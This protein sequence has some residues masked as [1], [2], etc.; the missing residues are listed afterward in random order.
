LIDIDTMP[1]AHR[2]LTE[3]YRKKYFRGTWRPTASIIF[4]RGCPFRCE[5]CA[6]WKI[7]NGMYRVRDPRAVVNEIAGMKEHYIHFIDDNTLENY[8]C[9]R[10]L[11]DCIKAEGIKK[12]YEVYGR[13]DTIVKHPDLIERWR[14]IG[15]KLVLIGFESISEEKLRQWNK[16]ISLKTNDEAIDIL[17]SN[18]IEIAAY[19]I[20]DPDFSREDFEAL[21]SYVESKKL[22]HPIFTV[23]SPFPGTELRDKRRKELITSSY[24]ILDF[25]HTVLP[26]RLP[27]K[28]FY[29]H[30]S[31]LY[32]RAYASRKAL[33]HVFKP[34]A[35]FS[36]RLIFGNKKLKRKL[37]ELY[38]H[39]EKA[40]SQNGKHQ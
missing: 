7:N 26:T 17:H 30:F 39:H 15:L 4:S 12:T 22:T 27:L 20:V 9:A 38:R 3:R 6:E 5:F 13:A 8:Q 10:R 18:G 19:F 35:F 2:A 31:G 24:Q 1:V 40:V 29:E 14:E 37:K 21:S 28:E 33:R 11:A 16:R 25:F 23:L 34:K 32:F 36:L